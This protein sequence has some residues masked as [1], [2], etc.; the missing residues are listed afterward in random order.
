MAS[1]TRDWYETAYGDGF[2]TIVDPNDSTIV[3]SES[4]GGNMNRYDLNTGEKTPM[5]PITGPRADGDTTKAY[6][7]N[8]NAPLQFS[9]HDSRTIYLGA[10]YLMR[11]R[12]RGMSWEEVGGIDLTKAIDRDTLEIMGVPGSEPQMSV[13]DGIST[14]GNLTT[15]AE[16]PMRPGLIYVGTD[17]GNLQVTL[18]DGETWENVADRIPG[19]PERTYVSRVEPS[20]HVE[21]RVYATFDGHRNGDF[22]PYAYVSEDYG[23]SWSAIANGLPD[24][25]SVNVIVEHHRTPGLLFLGNEV[26]VYVSVDRGGSWTR[27]KNDLPVVPVDDIVVHPRE[28]DLIVG[29]H[30]RSL[31]IM[32]DVAPLERI[33][34]GMLADAGGVMPARSIMWA[35]RGDWPFYG[36]TYSASNPPRGARIRY[37]LRD[38]PTAAE[39][40]GGGN[41]GSSSAPTGEA[42]PAPE[43]DVEL[44]I[45][46]PDG[47]HVRTLEGPASPGVHELIWDWRM[48]PPYEAAGGGGPGGGPG[49]FF[50]GGAPAGPIVL[51]GT[52]TVSLEAG[53]EMFT[54]EVEV[55]AD[56]RRPMSRADRLARQHALMSLHVLAKPIYEAGR[57]ANRIDEQLEAARELIENAAEPSEALEEEISAIEEELETVREDLNEARRNAGVAG[58]IQGSSTLPTEDQLWQVDE[59]WA[60]MPGVVERLNELI[61]DR[62]PDLNRRIYA[63]AVRPTVEEA[64]ELPSRPNG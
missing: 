22:A 55:I 6:R 45:T 32:A 46:G 54:S 5:R 62:V 9:P 60:A 12:D 36:A 19:L 37:Y 38:A 30:G 35:Q 15:L 28:N 7:F 26:G 17:D 42:Q 61:T 16:S 59:A 3:F 18:D 57:A 2:F 41:G 25:W 43:D 27:M 31:Y 23:Q 47:G 49:G 1:G 50:G 4:Q 10:N 40:A 63:D 13:N 53:G 56:P 24:L 33:A 39:M 20:A 44:T 14:Y 48:D 52:Y 11:S 58:A 8:W 21:G 51:P 34:E 64:I 29:T